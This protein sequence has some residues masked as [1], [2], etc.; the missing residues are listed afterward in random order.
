MRHCF[1]RAKQKLP[2]AF[3]A[4]FRWDL[5]P[6]ACKNCQWCNATHKLQLHLQIYSMWILQISS[7]RID[8]SY[9]FC[10]WLFL[11]WLMGILNGHGLNYNLSQS[12]FLDQKE[13]TLC[14]EQKIEAPTGQHSSNL[15]S[16]YVTHPKQ[17]NLC[18]AK[19]LAQWKAS[20]SSWNRFWR[21][22]DANYPTNTRGG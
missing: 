14:S 11:R 19:R 8:L 21:A 7:Q 3:T 4:A 13:Q 12:E 15:D 1:S 17:G 22:D 5:L 18:E 10:F 6:H 2:C 20:G 16:T 9:E